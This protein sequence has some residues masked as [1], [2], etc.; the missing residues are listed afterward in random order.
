MLELNDLKQRLL[1]R[2]H[3]DLSLEDSY[4]SALAGFVAQVAASR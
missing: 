4:W 3:N 2:G 1:G